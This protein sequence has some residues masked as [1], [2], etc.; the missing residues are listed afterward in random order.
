MVTFRWSCF[1]LLACN[2][3]DCT[4]LILNIKL[5]VSIDTKKIFNIYLVTRINWRCLD[6]VPDHT[7]SSEYKLILYIHLVFNNI[8][9]TSSTI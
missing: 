3:F 6:A 9:I 7:E 2:V 4:L 1:S 5:L 8:I